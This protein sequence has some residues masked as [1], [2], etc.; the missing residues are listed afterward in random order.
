MHLFLRLTKFYSSA[1]IPPL[2]HCVR[3][4]LLQLCEY[5]FKPIDVGLKVTI[6]MPTSI[7]DTAEDLSQPPT[8]VLRDANPMESAAQKDSD[9]KLI[10]ICLVATDANMVSR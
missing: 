1:D 4:H 5:L 3:K 6:R 10:Y 9:G 7:P 8:P 2:D